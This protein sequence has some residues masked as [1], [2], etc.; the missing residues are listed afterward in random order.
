V[1]VAAQQEAQ[2]ES[3]VETG[4]EVFNNIRRSKGA[5]FDA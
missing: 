5:E 1:Y 4:V 2:R 3:V